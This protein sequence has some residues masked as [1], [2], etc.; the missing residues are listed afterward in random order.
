MPAD[1]GT[2]EAPD[3]DAPQSGTAAAVRGLT[4]E[5]LPEAPAPRSAEHAKDLYEI[6]YYF[7]YQ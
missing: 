5:T 6:C 3:I 7:Y 1:A 2:A 4:T